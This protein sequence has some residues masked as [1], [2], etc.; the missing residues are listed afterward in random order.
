MSVTLNSLPALGFGTLTDFSNRWSG[1]WER[2]QSTEGSNYQSLTTAPQDGPSYIA[3]D[4]KSPISLKGK[5]LR[6]QIRINSLEAWQGIE[7]R[8]A[9]DASMKDYFAIN[10]PF[11]SD[12]EFN[13]L[14]AGQWA[15]LTLS[16]GEAR[17]EGSPSLEKI[18]HIGF[19]VAGRQDASLPFV[20]D[21]RDFAIVESVPTSIVSMTF[22]DGYDDHF[23]AAEIMARYGLRG[24]AYVMTNEINQDGYLTTDQL[25][26]MFGEYGWSIS[27][28]HKI[29]ITQFS[30]DELGRELESTFDFLSSLGLDLASDHFAYPLGKQNRAS[31]LPLIRDSFSTARIAG[32]GAETLP[33]SDWHMLRT[34]N[35]TPDITPE[36]LEERIEKAKQHNEWLI[37]MFH[38]FT[39]EA[40]QD[41]LTINYSVFEKFCEIIERSGVRVHPVDEVYEAFQ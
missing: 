20:M 29:P 5:H 31:T 21:L 37:L 12:P 32:G 15:E 28:H 7:V 41:D 38:Y 27:S 40:P 18:R 23:K 6:L 22:D 11:Y 10:I 14:Q 8:I 17:I 30:L 19:Y 4:S 2:H 35:V 24:T 39:D 36:M 13:F 26:Q 3:M 34:F 9:E 33:P 1:S 16:L 25:L